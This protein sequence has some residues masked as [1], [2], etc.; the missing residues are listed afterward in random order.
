MN[1]YHRGHGIKLMA[2][3][4]HNQE[5]DSKDRLGNNIGYKNDTF[6]VQLTYRLE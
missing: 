1:Y 3:Y 6:I 2:N 4:S 5:L